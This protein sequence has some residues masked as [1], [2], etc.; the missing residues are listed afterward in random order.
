MT[1][2]NNRIEILETDKHKL[3]QHCLKRTEDITKLAQ[4]FENI[5]QSLQYKAKIE[6][7]QSS[8]Q[9]ETG[10]GSGKYPSKKDMLERMRSLSLVNNRYQ[11]TSDKL[12]VLNHSLQKNRSSK[13]DELLDIN[14]LNRSIS[15]AN[16]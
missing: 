9:E 13:D 14:T 1:T 11:A 6:Y 16:P 5:R 4:D 7:I 15:T 8:K 3:S 2:L 10:Y 12:E